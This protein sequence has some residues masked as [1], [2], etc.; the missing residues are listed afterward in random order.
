MRK[1][2]NY[3]IV[4]FLIFNFCASADAQNI[5]DN[6]SSG[7]YFLTTFNEQ[8]TPDIMNNGVIDGGIASFWQLPPF[9]QI[10]YLLLSLFAVFSLMKIAPYVF[11]R[12]KHVLE[13]PK[14][15]EI[16]GFIQRNPG[17]TVAELS[18]ER[19]INRGTLKYHLGQLLSNNKIMF[20]RKG[21]YLRLFY[22]NPRAMD[23]ESII[24]RYL[25]HDKNKDFLFAI[26][27]Y[28]GITNQDL[29]QKFTLDKSTVTDYLKKFLDDGLIEYRQDGKFKRC[30]LR[31]DARLILL[32]HRPG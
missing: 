28:P 6:N 25:K 4:A 10:T 17:V 13:N 14:T 26:M 27:D 32:H 31:Q 9:I 18:K 29:S 11:G 16:Y 22:N 12:L 2:S 5:N 20:V 23:K 21:K 7:G 19:K 30:Y 15:K 1:I 8:K 24:A 3:L